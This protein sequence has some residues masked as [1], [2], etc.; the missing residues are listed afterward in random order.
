MGCYHFGCFDGII[1]CQIEVFGRGGLNEAV[2][3]REPACHCNTAAGPFVRRNTDVATGRINASRGDGGVG[4]RLGRRLSRLLGGAFG[5]S[6]RGVECLS[7]LSSEGLL[8]LLREMCGEEANAGR[9]SE[10]EAAVRG[11]DAYFR[12]ADPDEPDTTDCRIMLELSEDRLSAYLTLIPPRGDGSIPTINTIRDMLDES[13]V[14]Y[15]LDDAAVRRCLRVVRDDRDIVWRAAIARG[16]Q[17]VPPRNKSAKYTVSFIDKNLLRRNPS[18]L[19][20]TLSDLWQPVEKGQKIGYMMD[21]EPGVAG[22]DVCGKTVSPSAPRVTLDV[23]EEIVCSSDGVLTAG[24]TGYVIA[25]NDHV[26][27]LPLYVIDQPAAASVRDAMFRGAVLVRGP[28]LGPGSIE[29]DD[30]F[31]LGDCE[32]MVISSYGDV[33]VAGGIIGRRE[34]RVDADGGIYCTFISEARLSAVGEVVVSNAIMNSD[35][36]SNDVIRVTSPKGI[37][38]GGDLYSLKG[39]EAATIGSEFGLPTNVAVGKDFL[40]ASRLEDVKARIVQYEENLGRIDELKREIARARVPLEKLPSDKQEIYIG[41]LKKEKALRLELKALLRRR[42]TLGTG[43]EEFLSACVRAVD[44]IYPP[45][46]IQILDA[47][48]EVKEKMKT[49]TLRYEDDRVVSSPDANPYSASTGG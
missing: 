28:L 45:S 17:P 18:V 47:V 6:R 23:G 13:R 25:D 29:C 32:Q 46:H 39:I 12:A 16:D 15:G 37:I 30:L 35:V 33:Y 11:L 48:E 3:G 27:I 24:T 43:L 42:K 22:R 34:S 41:V 4:S 5:T 21:P 36:T 38:A 31:V 44:G 9:K 2:D 40:T 14:I 7:D 20:P 1:F 26:D 49:A 10:L 8:R 19:K